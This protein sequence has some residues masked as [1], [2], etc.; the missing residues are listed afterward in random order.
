ME[1]LPHIL[2]VLAQ[3]SLEV[4]K[5]VSESNVRTVLS[6][7]QVQSLA[8]KSGLFKLPG[9]T[10]FSPAVELMD[11]RWEVWAVLDNGF[12]DEVNRL[13]SGLREHTAILA[14]REALKQAVIKAGG[15]EKVQTM[16]V[17]CLCFEGAGDSM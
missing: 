5:A 3:A 13:V 15:L 11:G 4:H 6:M 17:F 14:Q 12:E 1:Q 2:A 9:F 10:V 16:D 8:E 7:Q